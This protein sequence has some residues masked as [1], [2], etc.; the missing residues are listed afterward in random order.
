MAEHLATSIPFNRLTLHPHMR[1]GKKRT[2]D[3]RKSDD[4]KRIVDDRK[5]E[6]TT[7]RS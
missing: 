2:D 4:D 5:R 1:N 7:M 6:S 3:D